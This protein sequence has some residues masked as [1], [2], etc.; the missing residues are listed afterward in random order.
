MSFYKFKSEIHWVETLNDTLNTYWSKNILSEWSKFDQ[1]STP[2]S[3]SATFRLICRNQR[4]ISHSLGLPA[5]KKKIKKSTMKN[6]SSKISFNFAEKTVQENFLINNK[7]LR[8]KTFVGQTAKWGCSGLS[9][10][11]KIGG[12]G[13]ESHQELGFYCSTFLFFSWRLR[14]VHDHVPL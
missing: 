1:N 7:M 6:F 5:K 9:V 12:H 2:P 8:E 14:S 4:S 11:L 13:F 10:N 3:C